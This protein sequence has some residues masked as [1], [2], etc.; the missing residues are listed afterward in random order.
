MAHVDFTNPFRPGAG[1]MPP[2]L[3]GREHEQDEC[4]RLLG[5]RVIL[6]NMVLTGLRG[7]GKTVLLDTF[8]PIAMGASWLWVG[9][10]LSESTSLTEERVATRLM[11]DMAVVTSPVVV[12]KSELKTIGFTGATTSV[13]IPTKSIA[14]SS[15]SRSPVPG[16][17]IT[18]ER[19]DAGVSYFAGFAAF[20][21]PPSSL[22]IESPV[23]LSR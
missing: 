5:Q 23:S 8:K 10:D 19:S 13:R 1:H 14:R 9:T 21:K 6:E 2:Y 3:A 20:V 7:V 17:A 4:R 22:R 12:G 15:R 11:A 18:P 16:M